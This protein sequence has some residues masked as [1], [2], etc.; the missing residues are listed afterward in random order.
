[1]TS[2]KGVVGVPGLEIEDV[3]VTIEDEDGLDVFITN[4]LW[5]CL[6]TETYF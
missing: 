4:S 6:P 2:G 5:L 3:V 1:M